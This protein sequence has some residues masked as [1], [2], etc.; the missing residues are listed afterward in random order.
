[1]RRLCHM[2]V[3][4]LSLSAMVYPWGGFIM[5]SSGKAFGGSVK[6][7]FLVWRE[8]QTRIDSQDCW[9]LVVR[10]L[11]WLFK[12]SQAFLICKTEK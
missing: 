8:K 11:G 3:G 1:M 5:L 2:S 9:L 10:S 4:S 6:A 7:C 12:F